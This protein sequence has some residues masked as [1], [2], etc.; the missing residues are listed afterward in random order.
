MKPKKHCN[1]YDNLVNNILT[2]SFRYR[3]SSPKK[4]LKKT[5]KR[6]RGL[7]NTPHGGPASN[8]SPAL[9]GSSYGGF[10]GAQVP[11]MA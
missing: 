11:S 1:S 5:S 10:D 7:P 6:P 2:R 3:Y 4:K 8:I 9:R